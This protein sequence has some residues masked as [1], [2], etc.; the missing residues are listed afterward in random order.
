M[1]SAAPVQVSTRSYNVEKLTGDN[2]LAWRV[3][4]QMYLGRIDLWGIVT[5][6][7]VD[8]GQTD[9]VA[10]A[11]WIQKDFSAQTE[12]ILPSQVTILKKLINLE[13]IDEQ[14]TD[15][16]VEEWQRL[17]DNAIIAGLTIP[18][19][20]QVMLLLAALPSSWRP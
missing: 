13:M 9:P 12:L 3:K 17:L 7:G 4:M 10:H 20:L 15:K 6:V 16:F 18:A 1:A 5:G 8:P 11:D 14:A 19:D 2:Y